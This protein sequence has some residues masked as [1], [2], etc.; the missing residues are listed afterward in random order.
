DHQDRALYATSLQAL[1]ALQNHGLKPHFCMCI[2]THE[3]IMKTYDRLDRSWARDIP[4][5]YSTN[6]HPEAGLQWEAGY[7]Q[8]LIEKRGDFTEPLFQGRTM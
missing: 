3:A 7:G 8:G 4:L 2:E 5:I 1:P 6:T